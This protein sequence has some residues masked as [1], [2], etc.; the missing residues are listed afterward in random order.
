MNRISCPWCLGDPLLRAYHDEEWGV[1][2][3]HD[4]RTQFE[5]LTLEAM[6][7]GLSW[8]TVL[9]K[10]ESMRAAF[11]NFDPAKIALYNEE[12]QRS[13]LEFPG[14]IHSASKI[15]ATVSNAKLF[16]DIQREFGSFDRW[17]WSFTDGKTR[18]YP[19]NQQQMP[20][21]NALSRKIS[22]ALKQRGFHYLGPV[23]LYSHM[24]AVGMVND[25]TPDCFAYPLLGGEITPSE[26]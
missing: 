8:M 15:R 5:F 4:D 1:R 19:E 9:R 7:C 17:F 2:Q 10:R 22:A 21:Q 16:L 23:V 3:V 24:Q 18:L 20:A 6:Q 11:D 25:H 12:K 14:I 13:L 26:P